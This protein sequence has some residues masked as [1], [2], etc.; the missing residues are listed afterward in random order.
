MLRV[1]ENRVVETHDA[2]VAVHG[3]SLG[4]RWSW[5]WDVHNLTVRLRGFDAN[6]RRRIKNAH[7]PCRAGC[8]ASILANKARFGST[9]AQVTGS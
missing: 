6:T 3:I 8:V 4:R 9:V 7:R 1:V 5:D 2:V